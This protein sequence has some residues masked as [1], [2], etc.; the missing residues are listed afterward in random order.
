[1]TPENLQWLF[2]ELSHLIRTDVE[3]AEALC[4][5]VSRMASREAERQLA[6]KEGRSPCLVP[7]ALVQPTLVGLGIHVAGC[8]ACACTPK[9]RPC[10]GCGNPGLVPHAKRSPRKRRGRRS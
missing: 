1:M 4:E 6:K 2:E 9:N 3:G 10:P 8:S 7:V 5:W